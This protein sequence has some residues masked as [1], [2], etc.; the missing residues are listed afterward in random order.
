MNPIMTFSWFLVDNPGIS[1]SALVDKPMK[2]HERVVWRFL[3]LF[4]NTETTPGI[5]RECIDKLLKLAGIRAIYHHHWTHC[6]WRALRIF[7]N[8]VQCM[9]VTG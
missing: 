1:A 7:R 2:S 3:F 9:E 5:S 8:R 4:G 6:Q